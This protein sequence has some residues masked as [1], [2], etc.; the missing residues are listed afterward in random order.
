MNFLEII[1]GYLDLKLRIFLILH[2]GKPTNFVGNIKYAV[3]IA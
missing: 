1:G 2:A 3:K